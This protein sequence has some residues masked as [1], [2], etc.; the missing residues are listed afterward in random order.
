MRRLALLIVLLIGL[1]SAEPLAPTIFDQEELS[2]AARAAIAS[3]IAMLVFVFGLLQKPR[4][5]RPAWD[6]ALARVALTG[7]IA[8]VAVLCVRLAWPDN[9]ALEWVTAAVI[10][11]EGPSAI[12]WLRER[13]ANAWKG[14]KHDG[15]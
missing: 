9:L 10:G 2:G 7:I 11:S 5:Q 1:S 4:A 14:G 12:R 6:I 8:L 3:C 13:F 15:D